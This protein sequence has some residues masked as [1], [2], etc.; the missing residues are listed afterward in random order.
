MFEIMVFFFFLCKMVHLM[1]IRPS[2][3]PMFT[4][5]ELERDRWIFLFIIA[6]LLWLSLREC[7]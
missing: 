2:V 5:L 6:T 1:D 3:F 7:M 4:F